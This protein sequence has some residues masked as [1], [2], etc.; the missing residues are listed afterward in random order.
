MKKT[1]LEAWI[2]NKIQSGQ[3]S[4]DFSACLESRKLE[5]IKSV[6]R[7]VKEASPF[8]RDRLKGIDPEALGSLSDFGILPFTSAEDLQ[9]RG[10][11]MV[12]V[13]QNR[14]SRIVTLP[15]SGTTGNPKRVFFTE[16]DQELTIDFFRHGMGTFTDPKDKVLILMPGERPGSVGDLLSL[17]LKRLGARGYIHGPAV[18]LKGAWETLYEV[19]PEIIVGFPRQIGALVKYG[20]YMGYSPRKLKTVLLSAD[21]VPNSLVSIISEHW[22]CPVHEHYGMTEMGLGGGVTCSALDGYHMRE[23]DMHIEVINPAT[24]NPAEEGDTG[25]VVFTTLTRKGMPFIRYRTGDIAGK[26]PGPCPCGSVL[27]RL[28]KVR[29]RTDR[30]FILRNGT[31]LAASDADEV[32]LSREDILDYSGFLKTEAGKEII[33]LQ[34]KQ[35]PGRH[36][37]IKTFIEK[38]LEKSADFSANTNK[39]ETQVRI[40]VETTQDKVFPGPVKGLFSD[41]RELR[42]E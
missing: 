9:N 30:N 29:G 39:E 42:H 11:E 12:C 2:K 36:Q 10:S 38:H 18:S 19:N 35:L 15:T 8:Y 4:A 28:G 3:G 34:V 27:P 33:E 37:N 16:E 22:K 14:I 1:P 23:A 21:Y 24:G 7:E 13:S 31:V 6:L 32:I 5:R 26:V 41:L 25:E 40:I 17:A 20:I